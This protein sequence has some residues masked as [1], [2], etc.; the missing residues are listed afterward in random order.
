[1]T[2]TPDKS[3]TPTVAL[4]RL[5]ILGALRIA[6]LVVLAIC[7]TR[8]QAARS[9]VTIL[10]AGALEIY[11]IAGLTRTWRW[12]FLAGLPFFLVGVLY[13]A[14]TLMYGTPPGRSLAFIL[15][16]TSMEEVLGFLGIAQGR[17]PALVF[18]VLAALYLFLAWRL[19]ASLRILPGVPARWRLAALALLLPAIVYAAWKPDE[20]IDGIGYDPPVGTAMFF[21]GT[22]PSARAT[23]Q[24]AQ[25]QKVPFHAHRDGGEEVHVLVLGESARRD[26]WSV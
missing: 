12:F 7:A 1:M 11:L 24:G 15:L 18:V 9:I 3:V 10:L 16:T 20:L 25:V 4:A 5:C 23:L 26:S 21:A 6:P 2:T 17:I 19:P 14:Y 13:A 22:V 8:Y